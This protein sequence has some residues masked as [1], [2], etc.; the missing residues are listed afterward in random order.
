MGV[1]SRDLFLP[2]SKS[3]IVEVLDQKVKSGV[4]NGLPFVSPSPTVSL[5]P[6]V[7]CGSWLRIAGQPTTKGH[8]RSVG[9]HRRP[10]L[11]V[12]MTCF[13]VAGV[14]QLANY[15]QVRTRHLVLGSFL[16]LSIISR[17]YEASKIN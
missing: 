6:Q 7:T 10:P 13:K 12:K 14:Q 3:L 1:S 11:T 17:V 2:I 16:I 8:L 15:G 9:Y 5:S 4:F